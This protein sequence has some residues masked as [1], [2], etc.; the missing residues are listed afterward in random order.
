M[1]QGRI[2]GTLPTFKMVLFVII[3]ICNVI[4]CKLMKLYK[5]YTALRISLFAS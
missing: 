3:G 2:W 4:F 5:H 1:K